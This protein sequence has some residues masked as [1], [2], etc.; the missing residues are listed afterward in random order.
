[1]DVSGL[2]RKFILR[3]P[4][5]AS[6]P[7]PSRF[8]SIDE[9]LGNAQESSIETNDFKH[10]DSHKL[11]IVQE[12]YS[13]SAHFFVKDRLEQV[14][15]FLQNNEFNSQE[16]E[17][18]NSMNKT[19]LENYLRKNLKL[20]K[21]EFSEDIA[22]GMD[23]FEA[24]SIGKL[25]FGEKRNEA[26]QKFLEINEYISATQASAIAEES[27]SDPSSLATSLIS[28]YTSLR[29]NG[30]GI[31]LDESV[32]KIIKAY[33]ERDGLDFTAA[34][35]SVRK[36][37]QSLDLD[38][39]GYKVIHDLNREVAKDFLMNGKGFTELEYDLWNAHRTF[40]PEMSEKIGNKTSLSYTLLDEMSAIDNVI[41]VMHR[42]SEFEK[43]KKTGISAELRKEASKFYSPNISQRDITGINAIISLYGYQEGMITEKAWVNNMAKI[44]KNMSAEANFVASHLE[45]YV[46]ETEF[47]VS[48]IFAKK[49]KYENESISRMAEYASKVSS[50]SSSV[51]DSIK[52]WKMP[53]FK[54]KPQEQTINL[55]DP[56]KIQN[57]AKQLKS[58]YLEKLA[59]FA[60]T[61]IKKFSSKVLDHVV[62][63]VSSRP[64]EYALAT[65]AVFLGVITPASNFYH[66]YEVAERKAEVAMS[67]TGNAWNTMLSNLTIENG[68]SSVSMELLPLP[69]RGALA[70]VEASSEV[71]FPEQ[72]MGPDPDKWVSV[73]DIKA[74][75]L[76][77][78]RL[79]EAVNDTGTK[80][81]ALTPAAKIYRNSKTKEETRFK[82]APR[83]PQAEYKGDCGTTLVDIPSDI[84][85]ESRHSQPKLMQDAISNLAKLNDAARKHG[86]EL[87]VVNAYRDAK[88]QKHFYKA[89][90]SGGNAAHEP[91]CDA[92]P[93]PT[94]MHGV[95]VD[96]ELRKNGAGPNYHKIPHIVS[97]VPGVRQAGR[98]QH[99]L[100]LVPTTNWDLRQAYLM[101]QEQKVAQK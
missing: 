79:E 63:S 7:E 2:F 92:L 51:L 62:D 59:N 50:F 5:E 12:S 11:D 8:K 49:E 27:W 90:Y 61:S 67:E 30:A 76:E 84:K 68:S 31:E 43:R 100:K 33:T 53:E 48:R 41:K 78:P 69:L 72:N 54:S 52:S 15:S 4:E 60:Y 83:K 98:E 101:G 6:Y 22:R 18:V 66:M 36:T 97:H 77:L 58:Q 87:V 16:L 93:L 55:P 85:F 17:V 10:T 94:H 65:V 82:L 19:F 46:Q 64:R 95:S 13:D 38:S 96:I 1:M 56:F 99:H 74:E 25:A 81:A 91:K 47:D 3:E 73:Y 32:S 29:P 21:A 9:L 80:V 45:D 86:Y 37:I 26:M 20:T 71:N 28:T 42:R 75:K 35:K 39:L 57:N 34:L 70:S 14:L 44:R 89:Q 40:T 23:I 24:A 88:D